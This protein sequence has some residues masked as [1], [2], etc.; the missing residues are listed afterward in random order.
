MFKMFNSIHFLPLNFTI[1]RVCV[2]RSHFDS[3]VFMSNICEI[4]ILYK[5]IDFFSWTISYLCL[6]LYLYQVYFSFYIFIDHL[7][8]Y[9]G[10]I[11]LLVSIYLPITIYKSIYLF[12]YFS[13]SSEVVTLTNQMYKR[14]VNFLPLEQLYFSS[15]TSDPTGH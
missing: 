11:Y 2:W 14:N 7:Y 5:T 9:I 4:K 1:K 8:L 15:L 6:Y 12:D 13:I 10:Y 3:F